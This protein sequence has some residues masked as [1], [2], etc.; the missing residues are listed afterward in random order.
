MARPQTLASSKLLIKLSTAA[1]PT[2]FAPQCGINS[3]S[4]NRSAES[5]DFAV[6]DCD[7]LDAPAW[8]E[9]EVSTLQSD[10]SGNGWLVLSG[11]DR[12]D[13]WL[14]KGDSRPVQI[15][16]NGTRTYQGNYKLTKLNYGAEEKDRIKVEVG[17]SSDGPVTRVAPVTP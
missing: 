15:E 1:A 17:L 16:I 8:L 2:V 5:K 10:V 12:W 3:K 13:D 7:D 11:A 9:R 4:F 14:E 6:Y